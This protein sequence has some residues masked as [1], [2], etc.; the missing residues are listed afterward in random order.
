MG[1]AGKSSFETILKLGQSKTVKES[2]KIIKV[3]NE[4]VNKIKNIKA[5]IEDNINKLTIAKQDL[6]P[7]VFTPNKRYTVKNYTEHAEK[8]GIFILNKKTE[9]YMQQGNN[10]LCNTVLEL[11]KKA[12]T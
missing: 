5:D 7:S 11:S 12:D 4:N 9:I 10:F 2:A 8:D 1:K 6:D 3:I